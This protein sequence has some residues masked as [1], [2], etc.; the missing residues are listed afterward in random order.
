MK[1]VYFVFDGAFGKHDAVHMVRQIGLHLISQLRHDSALYFSYSGPYA[2]GGPRKK[3]GAKLNDEDIPER[4]LKPSSTDKDIETEIYQMQ[5]W[6]KKFADLLNVVAIV[7]TNL[8]T[9]KVAHVVWF[10]SDLDLPYAL[11]MD[12]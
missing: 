1:I 12:Y 2:G 10:S 5:M 11:V 9:H 6:H 3:Y 7:K 4:Y 8:K